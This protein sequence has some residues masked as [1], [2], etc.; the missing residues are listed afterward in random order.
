MRP[1]SL[2]LPLKIWNVLLLPL[3]GWKWVMTSS[4]LG[5]LRQLR[6]TRMWQLLLLMLRIDWI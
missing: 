2:W 3:L 1:W 6:W 5:G 4:G